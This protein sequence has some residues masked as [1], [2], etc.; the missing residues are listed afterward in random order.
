MAVENDSAGDRLVRLA[1][2]HRYN[3]PK[4]DK[5]AEVIRGWILTGGEH[6]IS[7]LEGGSV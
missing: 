6:V 3:G 5:E 4:N 2:D 7:R 1:R